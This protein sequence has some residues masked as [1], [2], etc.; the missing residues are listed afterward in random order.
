MKTLRPLAL[1]SSWLVA[2]LLA[3]VTG[4]AAAQAPGLNEAR[5][6]GGSSSSGPVA[7]HVQATG[8]ALDERSVHEAILRELGL[9][10]ASPGEAPPVSI[11][12]RVV[13]DGDLTVTIQTAEGRG[14][15]RSVA[16]PARAD[17]VPEVTALL[18]GNLAR[19]EASGLLA[20]LRRPEPE[21]PS[22]AASAAPE[23][24]SEPELPLES[25]NLSLVYPLTLRE[26]TVSRRFALEL[27]L[28]Y[29]RIGALSGLALSAGGVTHVLGSV[30]GVMIG[31]IGY[32]HGGAAEGVR[33][34][35][36][37]GVGGTGLDGI[38]LAG[39]V[40][41]ER[42]GVS[43]GQIAGGVNY[44]EGAVDGA[45]IGGAVNVSAALRGAQ[46]GGALNLVQGDVKGVQLAG[47]VNVAGPVQGAQVSGAFNRARGDVDGV[48]LSGAANLA[49]RIN[50]VQL[51]L[52]NIGADVNGTQIGIVNVARDVDGLQ[53]GLVNVARE[54]DGVSLGLVPYSS[55]GST[56]AVAWLGSSLPFNFGVRFDTGVL[57]V[58]P[59]FGLDPRA[60]AEIFG[61]VDGDYAPGLSLGHRLHLG[62]AFAD[63]D[64]NYSNRSDGADYDE[65]DIE[66]RYRLLGGIQLSRVFGIFAGGGVRHHFRTRGP[67]DVYVKPELSLGVQL[68]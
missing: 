63:L 30:D 52:V 60:N 65:H 58:M 38:S 22:G 49:D 17:E 7:L 23:P 61:G 8:L 37:L 64:V 19:D 50:G 44:A 43:G 34:G 14:V 3:S 27:G 57:Y 10:A 12:L 32:W 29:G 16:A 41:V 67:A 11:E 68:L 9:D 47:A 53:L 13:S 26:D 15:S 25:V 56:Q 46:I 66:L 18:V 36:V 31:G 2:A 5:P 4:R 54:V 35:G 48:Q 42:G 20:Q 21:S 45:Q 39:A 28:L 33:I 1:V 6:G 24:A 55:R 40:S 51:G 59:T 62:R